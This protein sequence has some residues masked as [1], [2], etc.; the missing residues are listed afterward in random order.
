M[1][2]DI[3]P[4]NILID[5]EG[6]AYLT[7]FGVAR[8]TDASVV[9]QEGTTIGTAAYL[10]PE[11]L[12]ESAV[13]PEADV[14]SLGLVLL[15]ALT[16]VRSFE[17]TGVEAAMARLAREPDIPED[18]PYPWT[19]LLRAM[20]RREP[21]GR[22]DAATVEDILEGRKPPPPV[23]AA[24]ADVVGRPRDR[25]DA[26]ARAVA[27]RRA[28]HASADPSARRRARVPAHAAPDATAD[29]ASR[30]RRPRRRRRPRHHRTL[31]RPRHPA[32]AS[33]T[34]RRPRWRPNP[35][36]WPS[37][38]AETAATEVVGAVLGSARPRRRETEGDPGAG[39]V[40]ALRRR[41]LIA[42][43]LIG[44]LAVVL[45][46]G[47]VFFVVVDRMEPAR[48]VRARSRRR[49]P[50]RRRASSPWRPP[51]STDAGH[52]DRA[53]RPRTPSPSTR[54]SWAGL[55]RRELRDRRGSL[56]RR[57]DRWSMP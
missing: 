18:L 25:R 16:G 39:F 30:E 22:L 54:C 1:H 13:G 19:P 36:A 41:P 3:K 4:A 51:R 44:A 26:D 29:A 37:P 8:L 49:A 15:E 31:R 14:Y 24:A 56:R 21:E 17:G 20:T 10:A 52:R 34:T 28:A 2:R 7:D 42:G 48:T 35:T 46:L 50:P 27:R 53:R 11:Q 38:D 12:Q 32:R 55:D 47:L 43:M 9:T 23:R 5:P 45:V 6:L 57:A 33:P 40:A